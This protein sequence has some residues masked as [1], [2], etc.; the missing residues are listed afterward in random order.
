MWCY[1]DFFLTLT[2]AAPRCLGAK[3]QILWELLGNGFDAAGSPPLSSLSLKSRSGRRRRKRMQSSLHPSSWS[4]EGTLLPAGW[5]ALQIAR[6]LTPNSGMPNTGGSV[7]CSEKSRLGRVLEE[8]VD[9]SYLKEKTFH[10][11]TDFCFD[12]T[13]RDDFQS[14]FLNVGNISREILQE[15]WRRAPIYLYSSTKL[16]K[17]IFGASKMYI[18]PGTGW[19]EALVPKHTSI[20]LWNEGTPVFPGLTKWNASTLYPR[21]RKM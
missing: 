12:L 21:E 5:A 14:V 16:K 4:L 18:C 11:Q 6:I 3:V 17:S 9:P 13:I 20:V 8:S 2:S 1:Q 10:L 15:W 19:L 7:L